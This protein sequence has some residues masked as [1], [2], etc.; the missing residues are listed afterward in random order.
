MQ[1]YQND[2]VAAYL[3]QLEHDL[4]E[5]ATESRKVFELSN[6]ADII[7]ASITARAHL[8]ILIMKAINASLPLVGGST[9]VTGNKMGRLYREACVYATSLLSEPMIQAKLSNLGKD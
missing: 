2:A 6:V 1:K 4:E 9:N 7:Q 3:E 5:C 8:D